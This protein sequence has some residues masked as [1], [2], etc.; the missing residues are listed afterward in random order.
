G[1]RF[2]SDAQ[3]ATGAPTTPSVVVLPDAI[4]LDDV[5]RERL[6]SLSKR[7]AAVVADVVPAQFD[8]WGRGRKDGGVGGAVLD[9]GFSRLEAL[10]EKTIGPPVLRAT[11]RRADGGAAPEME[12]GL[13]E[14]PAARWAVCVPV[15]EARSKDDGSAKAEIPAT[16]LTIEFAF[17]DGRRRAV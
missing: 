9:P 12:I 10:I 11:A 5:V 13:R 1:V 6:A 16:S 2:V 4:A 17:G 7:K 14:S 8:G 3:A 15:W